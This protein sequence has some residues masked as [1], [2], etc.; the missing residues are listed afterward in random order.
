MVEAG[1]DTPC[2]GRP[3]SLTEFWWTIL[4]SLQPVKPFC[5]SEVELRFP[6]SL[7]APLSLFLAL[8]P[9]LITY[10]VPG[11]LD[12]RPSLLLL[13]RLLSLLLWSRERPDPAALLEAGSSGV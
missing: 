11:T 10:T 1:A 4:V 9:G 7:P 3:G 13:W 5:E 12:C 2:S 6:L 8:Y